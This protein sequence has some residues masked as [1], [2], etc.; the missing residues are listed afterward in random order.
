M[1]DFW[2]FFKK[3][4]SLSLRENLKIYNIQ[5]Y[6]QFIIAKK[7]PWSTTNLKINIGAIDALIFLKTYSLFPTNIRV[8]SFLYIRL[9]CEIR[10]TTSFLDYLER[11]L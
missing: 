3:N 4:S 8:N 11:S 1:V 6:K 10:V 5:E 7:L 2:S 9:E